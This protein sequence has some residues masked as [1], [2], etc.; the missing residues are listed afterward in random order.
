MDELWFRTNYGKGQ[1]WIRRVIFGRVM[2][3]DELWHRTN[4]NKTSNFWTS[5]GSGWIMAKDKFN[6]YKYFRSNFGTIVFISYFCIIFGMEV[7]TLGVKLWI[8][9]VVPPYILTC[10]I[11]GVHMLKSTIW[12]SG[13]LM[14]LWCFS[15]NKDLPLF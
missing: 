10:N 1:T 4:L 13:K 2:V 7:S 6:M 11:L 12:L 3:Q 5:Y 14:K 8:G 9:F 15:T